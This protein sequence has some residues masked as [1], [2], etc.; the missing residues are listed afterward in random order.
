MDLSVLEFLKEARIV[1]RQL[2]LIKLN[3]ADF[4]KEEK[5]S[6]LKISNLLDES[7]KDLRKELK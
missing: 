2:N 1:H 3:K 7:I 4:S 6:I 5:Q